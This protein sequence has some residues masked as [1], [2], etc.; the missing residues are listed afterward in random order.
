MVDLKDKNK[1]SWYRS[2]FNTR[3]YHMLYRNRDEIEAA[4][5]I[6]RIFK[7][8]N[9]PQGSVLL[10][11]ACGRG[12]HSIYMNK[13]GYDVTGV[14]LS[15]K[16]IKAAKKFENET[17][18][19]EVHDMRK[20]FADAN[21][22]YV[23]NLFTSFGYFPTIAENQQVLESA[24]QNLKPKGKIIIDF[25][26]ANQVIEG[27][28]K[29]ETQVIDGVI[30]DISREIKGRIIHKYIDITDGE[31]KM[32]YVEKVKALT[33][34]DF[35]GMLNRTN[36]EILDTFGNYNLEKYDERSSSRLIIIA[37]KFL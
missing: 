1:S 29:E 11:L 23:F 31:N 27:L 12:R 19:F 4:H 34:Q 6:D 14:D 24:Y 3:Y 9:P 13:K 21:F 7:Y 17:L 32:R 22:D 35:I 25:L 15:V 33:R 37:R 36:F 5:F 8:L 18:H 2:W 10:D 20:P 28:V 30:F 26:N 16:N